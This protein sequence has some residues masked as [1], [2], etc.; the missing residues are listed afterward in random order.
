MSKEGLKRIELTEKADQ[1]ERER[2][3]ERET[4]RERELERLSV[5]NRQE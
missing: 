5:Q 4:E 3:R 1:R 2:E